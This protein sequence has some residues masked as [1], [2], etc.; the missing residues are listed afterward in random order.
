MFFKQFK[1]N[2]NTVW[3]NFHLKEVRKFLYTGIIISEILYTI[4]ATV[5]LGVMYFFLNFIPSVEQLIIVYLIISY[6]SL[7]G[8]LSFIASEIIENK[9][10]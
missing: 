8:T 4:C 1:K 7:S 9:K 5:V 6:F 10:E 3:T 2:W